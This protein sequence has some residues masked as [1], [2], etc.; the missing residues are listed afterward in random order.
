LAKKVLHIIESLTVG[1][2]ERLLVGILHRLTDFENHVIILDGPETLRSEL[3]A[4]CPVTNLKVSG[5][6]SL[7]T[8]AG[9]IRR[10]IREQQIDIV[11]SHLYRA[12]IMARLGT[13]KKV[14]LINSI[15]AISSLASYK[16]R[17]ETLYLE[18]LT[19]R[20]RH[21]ILAV[22]KEVLKDFD[23][24][25]GIKGKGTVLYNFI[26]D[27]FFAA[28][29]KQQFSSGGLKLVAVG[30]LRHQKNYP[31]LVE[32]FKKMPPNV[33]VDIY[34]EG[35]MREEL[36]AV[37]DTNHLNIRLCGIRNDLDK[38]LSAYDAFIMT[39][40]YEGQPVALLEATACGL[41]ALLSDV[42]VL[43]EIGGEHAIYFD[44]ADPGDLVKKTK[45]VM[46]GKYD[47]KRLAEAG[48]KNIAGFAGMDHYIGALKK[49]YREDMG[50]MQEREG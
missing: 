29:R 7:F 38:V 21:H 1:G 22:S 47:L 14:P 4:G 48:Y 19:Y 50:A 25:V 36:Q 30:N 3:P 23:E 11:H 10:Y 17:R 20:K 37:I 34:G 24:W 18:K 28:P 45:E 5:W 6:L 42:P 41:P 32:A 49:I 46:A 43:R 40:F 8:K 31:Y 13:P 12:N 9:K 39:S 2:A 27:R 16:V 44:L 35:H 33:T 15:H 26:E